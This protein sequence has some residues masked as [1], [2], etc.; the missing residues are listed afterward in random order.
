MSGQVKLPPVVQERLLR[1]QQLQN[2]LQSVLTQKQQLEV[3]LLEIDQALDALKKKSD[4]VIL[5]K[6][7][8]ALFVKEKKLD[9]IEE[10][11]EKKE[12]SNMRISVL[13]KQEE[14][15]KNQIKELQVK[16]QNDLRSV[17]T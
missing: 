9:V 2:T 15:L 14:R 17:S 1:L 10:L 11:V 8:G 6:A 3:N 13:T 7:I 12:L 4:D 5:Y 16:L